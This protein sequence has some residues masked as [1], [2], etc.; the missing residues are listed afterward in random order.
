MRGCLH[1]VGLQFVIRSGHSGRTNPLLR[2]RILQRLLALI[3]VGLASTL[4]GCAERHMPENFKSA[5]YDP[6]KSSRQNHVEPE[7]N[8]QDQRVLKELTYNTHQCPPAG[9]PD[10][11][12]ISR[13]HVNRKVFPEQMSMRY[14]PGDRFNI[15]VANSPDFNGDYVINA[16]GR[17]YLPFAGEILAVGLTNAELIKRVEGALI[18][19][20][21]FKGD[22]LRVS[23]RPVLY[24][25]IQITVAG[26][27]FNPGRHV[28]NN[29]GAAGDKTDK[30]L[31]RIGDSPIDRFIAAAIGSAG[32]VRP[33][34]DITRIKLI[35]AGKTYVLNWQGAITGTVV[36]DVPLLAGDHI[37]VPESNCFQSLLM[38]PSQ[39]TPPGLRI[40]ASNLTQPAQNNAGSALNASSTS[41]PYGTRFL[42]GLVSANCVGGSLASNASRYGVLI[43]RNPKTRQT[44]VIQRPVEE[45]VRSAHRDTINPYL[46]PDD[47]IACYDSAITDARE[48]AT[49]INT[50]LT[51]LATW[52]GTSAAS[53]K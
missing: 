42:Q 31:T 7:A 52:R 41:V 27:V 18:K 24:A 15:F 25:P 13:Q 8:L 39:I 11:I 26:A 53:S 1:W 19:A 47:A 28:I 3:A 2:R 33:D 17:V 6:E 49:T 21:L 46:M 20:A 14:S 5:L 48:V 9:T 22:Y 51:P 16:D 36:D 12:E 37:E 45:L 50:L 44:E 40:F 23:V 34:A 38:Q 4:A 10:Y 32:G 43:S 35:R 29:N 30:V